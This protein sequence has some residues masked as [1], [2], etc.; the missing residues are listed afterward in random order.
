MKSSL[1]RLDRCCG[2]GTIGLCAAKQGRCHE[3]RIGP[4]DAE[5]AGTEGQL[6]RGLQSQTKDCGSWYSFPARSAGVVS[7]PQLDCLEPLS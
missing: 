7:A 5:R 3:A 1:P 4:K 2:V 6:G